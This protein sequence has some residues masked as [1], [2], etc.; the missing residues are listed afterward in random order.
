MKTI[1]N[2]F[3]G[4]GLISL[5]LT[6]CSDFDE[7][8]TDPSKT[9]LGSVKSYYALNQSFSKI[10]MDPS[11]GER[12]YVYN[13][14]EGAR[15]ITEKKHLSIGNYDD[16]YIS[17]FYYPAIAY[18]I[19][20]A[21]LAVQIA[22]SPTIE[23]ADQKF[24]PNMKQ[25]A[26][27]WRA[28][29]LG[30]FTDC[31]GPCD[32]PQDLTGGLNPVY[33]SEKETYNYI[34]DELS[35][36]VKA[37]DITVEPTEDQAKCDPYFGYDAKKWVKYANSLRMRLAM[38]L[39]NLKDKDSEMYNKAIAQFKD[40]VSDLSKTISEDVDIMEIVQN[41]GWDDYSGPYTRSYNQHCLSGTLANLMTNLGGISIQTQ[42][43]DI[44]SK[45]IK[46]ANYLG[47]RFEKHFV[48]NTD[49]PTKGYWLDGL[50]EN[51]DP[52]ALKLYYLPYDS[53]AD[54]M[55]DIGTE[56]KKLKGTFGL[57]SFENDKDTIKIDGTYCWNG[58]PAGTTTSF[59]PS[60]SKNELANSSSARL[61]NYPI[62]G[63]QARNAEEK[64]VYFGPWETYFLIAEALERQW[65]T[66]GDVKGITAEEAYNKAIELSFIHFGVSEYYED[67]IK[68]ETYNRIGTS[69]AYTHT[70]P[71]SAETMQYIDGY[72][73]KNATVKYQY[74]DGSRTL[75][76]G[77]LNDHLSK[78]FTQKYIAQLPYLVQECWS[79]YRRV[80]L[81][82]FDIPANEKM[83]TG[84]DM[85]EWKPDSWTSG[86][87]WQYYPQRMRY[88]TTLD[89]AN[90]TEYNHALELLGGANTTM[91]PL[92]WS[93]G[94]NQK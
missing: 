67:Y 56:V 58:I 27:I 91:V 65:I 6:S 94:S 78:I 31:F 72:T 24:Y 70:T 51:L 1:N 53:K 20:N 62:L 17:S 44:D 36:A 22:E 38:R 35:D 88:P 68:S 54:N 90:P 42:R 14:G 74:P 55:I 25:F 21:T 50:P 49:N 86:Q 2:L 9:E 93:L 34:L 46:P 13:W 81:P 28:Y 3:W 60:M 11:T 52:R 5:G 12:V 32:L 19:N 92:W 84:T 10:Q 41:N 43:P 73:N 66:S 16:D 48:Q 37:I 4:L 85:T 7:V 77:Q 40:A 63:S 30:Q 23:I 57:I 71:A 82:F 29:L 80:G 59:S 76:G 47:K 75:Y 45:Y 64:M 26:R 39:S 33:S 69:V 79:D 87:K 61:N 18:S 83:M 89:N 15:F 8:N